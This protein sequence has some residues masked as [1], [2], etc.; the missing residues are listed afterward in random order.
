MSTTLTMSTTLRTYHFCHTE[1]NQN[2][3]DYFIHSEYKKAKFNINN[4][5]NTELRLAS[6]PNYKQVQLYLNNKSINSCGNRKMVLVTEQNKHFS[7]NKIK[8]CDKCTIIKKYL[9]LLKEHDKLKT[10]YKQKVEECRII[11]KELNED[12]DQKF[13]QNYTNSE[14][15]F[16]LKN[17]N[18]RFIGQIDNLKQKV[19]KIGYENDDLT[20]KN[21]HLLDHFK[22]YKSINYEMYEKMGKDEQIGFINYHNKLKIKYDEL[23]KKYNDLHE[24]FDQFKESV[25]QSENLKDIEKFK[26]E[27]KKLQQSLDEIQLEKE[28]YQHNYEKSIQTSECII[29]LLKDVLKPTEQ[30]KKDLKQRLNDDPDLLKTLTTSMIRKD[31]KITKKLIKNDKKCECIVD[32]CQQKPLRADHIIELQ[33][34]MKGFKELLQNNQTDIGDFMELCLISNNTLNAQIL[35]QYHNG[36]KK[37]FFKQIINNKNCEID[38]KDDITEKDKNILVL[39]QNLYTQTINNIIQHCNNKSYKGAKKIFQMAQH[40]LQQKYQNDKNIHHIM[41]YTKN[42]IDQDKEEKDVKDLNFDEK[43]EVDDKFIENFGTHLSFD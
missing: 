30:Q 28:L 18:I 23:Y 14:K 24:I 25:K 20:N 40:Y 8:K 38:Q 5:T 15:I 33:L 11:T 31:L 9:K 6:L 36:K 3:G 12:E 32:K 13:S 16:K 21:K 7:S 29:T 37:N 42:E 39:P 27:N 17:K 22:I 26:K 1:F 2:G 10:N 34:L 43:H 19:N 41:L 4:I 35:C